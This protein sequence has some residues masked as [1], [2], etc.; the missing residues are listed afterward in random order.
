MSK[1]LHLPEGRE[2]RV[3]T[4]PPS[5]EYRALDSGTQEP[6]AFVGQA[7]VCGVRSASLGFAGFRFVEIIDARALDGCDMSDVIGVFNH[8]PDQ[9]LGRT[10]NKT[11]ELT[12]TE[13]GGLAYRIPYDAQDPDHQRVM[14]KIE[15][16]DV[17]GSSFL[18]VAGEDDWQEEKT[19]D[20]GSLYVRTVRQIGTLYDVCPVT[21]P[22]YPDATAAKRSHDAYVAERPAPPTGPCPDLLTRQLALKARR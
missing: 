16:G 4:T 12:R 21:N 14:R 15:R 8:D 22:A 5:I 18:F 11:L 19:D 20:G 9:L 6:V 13:D 7:I 3:V 2:A 17:D 1:P 10:R